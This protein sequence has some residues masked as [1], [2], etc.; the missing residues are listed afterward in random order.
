[1][2]RSKR[3]SKDQLPEEGKTT[4]VSGGFEGADFEQ[5]VILV[6][7]NYRQVILTVIGVII[8]SLL[9]YQTML[10]L[11]ERK[12]LAVETA[13]REAES[14]DALINFAR[15]HPHHK[16]A[17]LAYLEVANKKY[18]GDEFIQ[19]AEYYTNADSELDNTSMQG[20]ARLGV[21]MSHLLL[22]NTDQ[23]IEAL[24]KIANDPS[25][26]DTYRAEAAYQ[27]AVN[28]WE[29]S[30]YSSLDRELRRIESLKKSGMWI[31]KA[32]V[33]RNSIPELRELA[34]N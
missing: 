15:E 29:K 18:D 31:S 25:L 34:D 17:G 26:L 7:E 14:D 6:W 27:L 28:F 3:K 22:G 24:E 12:E 13:F 23:G 30:D 4:A 9:V 16:L 1:M 10:Y 21:A 32:S 19:A 2:K 5:K 20:R 11:A 33:M 8:L